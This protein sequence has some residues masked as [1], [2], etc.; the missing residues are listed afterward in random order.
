MYLI[1]PV[2]ESVIFITPKSRAIAPRWPEI[3]HK[4]ALRFAKLFLKSD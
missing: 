3:L 4:D 1:P 2:K